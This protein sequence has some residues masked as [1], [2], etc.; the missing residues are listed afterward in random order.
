MPAD[1]WTGTISF[2]LVTIPVKMVVAVRDMSVSFNLLHKK[3]NARL[4][5]KM[6]CPKHIEVVPYEDQVRGYEIDKGKYVV[7]TDDELESVAPETSRNIEIMDF[8]DS[9]SVDPV[10]YDHPYYLIP[11]G[12]VKPYRLLVRVM[13]DMGRTGIAKFVMHEREYLAAL[14][15]IDGILCI[16]T[17]HYPDEVVSTEDILEEMKGKEKGKPQSKEVKKLV[18]AMEKGAGKFKPGDYDDKDRKRVK[19]LVKKL[20]RGHGL[21]ESPEPEDLSESREMKELMKGLKE[22]LK[23]SGK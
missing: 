8:V 19:S 15:S 20:K 7:V 13:S 16:I 17:M 6:I 4:E 10:V 14:H 2:G 18:K 9:G 5:R 22:Y 11:N 3:D 1:L 21:V 23:E 12:A